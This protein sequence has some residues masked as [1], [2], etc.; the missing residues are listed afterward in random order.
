MRL[1]AITSSAHCGGCPPSCCSQAA[2]RVLI[3]QTDSLLCR[4]G[5]DAFAQWDYIGAPWRQDDLWCVGKPWLTAVGGNGGF[6]LRSRARTLAC[7]D[8]WGYLRGQCEDVFYVE[9]MPKVGGKVASREAGAKFAVES[10]YAADP[11]GFH[12]AYKWLTAEQMAELLEGI[13]RE[14]AKCRRRTNS[15]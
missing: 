4:A 11:L 13:S 3:F 5:I 1:I 14:Y 10:V 9:T 6:S 7:L 12:A 15:S 8:A 2:E